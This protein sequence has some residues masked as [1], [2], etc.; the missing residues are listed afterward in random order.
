MHQPIQFNKVINNYQQSTTMNHNMQQNHYMQQNHCMQQNLIGAVA[1]F[2]R[3]NTLNNN[4][5]YYP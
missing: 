3:I 5:I 1:S 4:I 2:P